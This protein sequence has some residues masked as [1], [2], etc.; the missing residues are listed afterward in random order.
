MNKNEFM[1]RLYEGLHVLPQEEINSAMSYYEEYFDDAGPEHEL[2]VIDELEA[3]EVI[4]AQLIAASPNGGQGQRV[5]KKTEAK[6]CLTALKWGLRLVGRVLLFFVEIF[7][8]YLCLAGI[9]AIGAGIVGA[10][11]GMM[12]GFGQKDIPTTLLLAGIGLLGIGGGTIMTLLTLCGLRAVWKKM[13]FRREK[14]VEQKEEQNEE[15]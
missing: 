13:T 12:I 5:S 11:M 4:V 14:S 15:D 7:L 10:V 3:P 2:D 6:G 8:F 1:R 9:C